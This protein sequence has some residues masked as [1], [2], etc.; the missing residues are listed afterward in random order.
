MHAVPAPSIAVM[1]SVNGLSTEGNNHHHHSNKNHDKHILP[2][3]L[4]HTHKRE[5][6]PAYG[7]LYDA[8]V[9]MRAKVDAFLAEEPATALLRRAQEQARVSVRVVEEALERYRCV[10]C[11]LYAQDALWRG[12]HGGLTW[13]I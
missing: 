4:H 13:D 10:S 12:L 7:S 3:I 11:C 2:S 8:C 9:A 1:A 5:S 6:G